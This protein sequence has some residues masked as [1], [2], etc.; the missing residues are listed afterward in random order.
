MRYCLQRVGEGRTLDV[1]L[2]EMLA[3]ESM[4]TIMMR[5]AVEES[6]EIRYRR[7]AGDEAGV[8]MWRR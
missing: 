2:N 7:V 3:R 4:T 8:G 1:S 5:Q 6:I